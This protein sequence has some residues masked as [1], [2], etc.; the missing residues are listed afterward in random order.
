[1]NAIHLNLIPLGDTLDSLRVQYSYLKEN[2][3]KFIFDLRT[4]EKLLTTKTSTL[5]LDF[6]IQS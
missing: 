5:E 6:K 3:I 4:I 1:M 2:I